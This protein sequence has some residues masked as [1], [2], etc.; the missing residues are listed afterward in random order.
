MASSRAQIDRKV[1]Q[2]RAFGFDV[3]VEIRRAAGF[4]KM[5]EQN[6]Q[7]THFQPGDALI[8]DKSPARR[9]SIS[10]RGRVG[11]QF[12]SDAVDVKVNEVAIQRAL[13]QIRAGV[14]RLPI[15]D[16]V[17]RI[18]RDEM[19]RRPERKRRSAARRSV[20][21]PQP[22]LRADRSP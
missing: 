12:P 10:R 14:V 11:D 1:V 9:A 4:R 16:R 3:A 8:L 7:D 13:R 22:Q 17:Q 21:S 18:Q 15:G 2:R 5:F 6:P 20:K 19:R